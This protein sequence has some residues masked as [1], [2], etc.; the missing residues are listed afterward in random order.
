[1]GDLHL[2]I[3]VLGINCERFITADTPFFL[4]ECRRRTFARAYRNDKYVATLLDRPPRLLRSRSNTQMPLDLSD[5]E[6]LADL[7]GFAMARARLSV[8]GW[9]VGSFNAATW[10][11]FRFVIAAMTEEIFEYRWRPMTTELGDGLRQVSPIRF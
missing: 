6:L 11:R 5:D 4:A 8:D 3:F 10:A 1:M 9:S 7:D 2:D